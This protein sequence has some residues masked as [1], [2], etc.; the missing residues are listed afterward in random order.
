MNK[1]DSAELRGQALL[2][3]FTH[4]H[5]DPDELARLWDCVLSNVTVGEF[6]LIEQARNNVIA[7]YFPKE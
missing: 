6:R 5:A 7:R 3:L 1:T 4:K 2:T